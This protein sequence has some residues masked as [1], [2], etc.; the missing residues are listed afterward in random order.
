MRD[1]DGMFPLNFIHSMLKQKS[2]HKIGD[3]EFV[4][5]TVEHVETAPTYRLRQQENEN[6]N[7]ERGNKL[8]GSMRRLAGTNFLKYT[9]KPVSFF[10]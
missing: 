5:A 10:F 1:K 3:V 4:C 7:W 6:W 8:K 2:E 9:K